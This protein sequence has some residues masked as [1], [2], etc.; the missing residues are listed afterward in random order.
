MP[1]PS[2]A[3]SFPA[4]L[5]SFGGPAPC[6]GSLAAQAQIRVCCDAAFTGNDVAHPLGRNIDAFGEPVLCHAERCEEF[7]CQ[8]FAW[9]HGCDQL[10]H[11]C[12]FPTILGTINIASLTAPLPSRSS[13]HHAGMVT[14]HIQSH[15]QKNTPLPEVPEASGGVRMISAPSHE[16]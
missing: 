6:R 16:H 9:R 11:A 15:R 5:P 1:P 2:T 3:Q 10:R 12:I 13:P 4:P 7:F 14:I 8:H